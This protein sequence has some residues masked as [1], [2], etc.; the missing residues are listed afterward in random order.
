[1]TTQRDLLLAILAMDSYNRG[2]GEGISGLGGTDS[3]IGE[4]TF[5]LDS[6]VLKDDAGNSV[7]EST[8]FYASSYTLDAGT[9]NETTV[10]SYRGTDG[11]TITDVEYGWTVSLGKIDDNQASQALEFYNKV[12]G[13]AGATLTGHSLGGGLAGYVAAVNGNTARVFDY[14]PFGIAAV[15]N[16]LVKEGL[17]TSAADLESSYQALKDALNFSN[18]SGEFVDNEILESVRN[19]RAQ[20]IVGDLLGTTAAILTPSIGLYLN[21]FLDWLGAGVGAVTAALDEKVSKSSIESYS[22]VPQADF[23]LLTL[24]WN[25]TD[26]ANRLHMIDYLVNLKFAAA[27]NLKAANDND[28]WRIAA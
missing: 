1:M 26:R 8:G 19:G 13:H 28:A 17:P 14:M 9:E 11:D 2:Y 6:G 15:V 4:A 16:K 27:E 12:E 5:K 20:A 21:G 24:A 10:I 18:I 22:G 23:S 3:K 7:H 25:F